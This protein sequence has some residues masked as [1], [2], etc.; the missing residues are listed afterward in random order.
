MRLTSLYFAVFAAVLGVLYYSIPGRFQWQLL[1]TASVVFYLWAGEEYLIFLLFTAITTYMATMQM[2]KNQA[3]QS[4]KSKTAIRKQNRWLMAACLTAN[5]GMLFLCKACLIKPFSLAVTDSPVS[6]L[7]LGLPLGISF[8]LFQTM[9]YVV[10]VYRGSVPAEGNFFRLLLFS[11]YFPQLIQGPISRYSRLA[12]QLFGQHAFDG[13]QV[14]FGAQRMLW[15]YFKKLVIADRIAPAV[16][17][18]RGMEGGSAFAALT[19]FYAV[20][21]YADFTG[22]IDVVL[23]LSQILGVTLPEN[24]IRP[25]FSKNTAEYWRRWH[26][27]LGEWMKEYIFYPVSVSKPMLRFSKAA[28][29]RFGNFGKRMPVYLASAVTWFVTGIWHGLTPNFILW[30]M[31]NWGVIVI[32]GELEP[33]YRRFHSRFRL[34]EK[35]W[36]GCFEMARMFC[37]MNLIRV[38][39]LFPRVSDYFRGLVSL[40]E[41][42]EPIAIPGLTGV[43]IAILLLG[44]AAMLLVSLIQERRGSVRELLW[45]KTAVGYCV[46]GALLLAVVLTGSYGVGYNAASFIYNQF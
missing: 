26:I 37:L 10:D 12:P 2:A 29:R 46:N 8:Y 30:G 21:L 11:S 40:W 25:F 9:G 44:C 1:L 13:K 28:R 31:L 36:Y 19:V 6:F 45:E 32:S 35:R 22:G 7:S 20:Q 23:G 39:D 43:D 14:S 33:V 27:S 3:R 16:T 15:G 17:V 41:R 4:G 24:F 34:K 42:W 38:C 18:L 5:F